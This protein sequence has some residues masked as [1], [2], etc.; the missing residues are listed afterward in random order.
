MVVWTAACM[1]RKVCC[2]YV[3]GI[4]PRYLESCKSSGSVALTSPV[5]HVS[6]ICIMEWSVTDDVTSFKRFPLLIWLTVCVCEP[7]LAILAW[8]S[9]RWVFWQVPIIA[10]L[11]YN[12]TAHLSPQACFEPTTLCHSRQMLLLAGLQL[13]WITCAMQ[14]WQGKSKCLNLMNG[15]ISWRSKWLWRMLTLISWVEPESVHLKYVLVSL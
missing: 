7:N 6:R 15:Q 13:D 9:F 4:K 14:S 10:N 1:L 5:T 3:S 12:P 8:V 2:I 11:K